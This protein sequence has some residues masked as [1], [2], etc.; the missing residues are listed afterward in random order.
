MCN[1]KI[2][3][4]KGEIMN[5]I[6]VTDARKEMSNFFDSV[7]FEKPIILKRRKY[8]AVL[9]EKSLL[10]EFLQDSLIETSLETD[11]DKNT[12]LWA[13]KLNVWGKGKTKV[14]ALDDLCKQLFDYAN[15]IYNNFMFYYYGQNIKDK[16]SYIFHILICENDDELKQI[17]V[18]NK[19]KKSKKNKTE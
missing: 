2:E 14:E 1:N 15:D 4:E 12:V 6:N 11:K 5:K 3:Q 18:I 19:S 9:I 13:S 7:I 8:E 10:K 17:I 16:L